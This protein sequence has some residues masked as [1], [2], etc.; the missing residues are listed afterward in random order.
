MNIL[1]EKIAW[2]LRRILLNNAQ[3]KTERNIFQM[4]SNMS[5]Y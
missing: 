2:S 3:Y 1:K 5:F 4:N